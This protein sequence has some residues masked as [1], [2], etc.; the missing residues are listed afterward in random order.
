LIGENDL[1]AELS[2]TIRKLM[3]SRQGSFREESD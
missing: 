1:C 3:T 2:V